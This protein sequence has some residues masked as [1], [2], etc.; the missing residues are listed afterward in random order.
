MEIKNKKLHLNIKGNLQKFHFKFFAKIQA[1][2]LGLLTHKIINT[3]EGNIE[4]VVEGENTK[5]WEMVKWCKKGPVFSNVNEVALQFSTVEVPA[6][7]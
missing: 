7:V 5:L 3:H 4:I 1:K 2:R 6:N